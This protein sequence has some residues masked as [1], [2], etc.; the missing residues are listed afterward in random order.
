[1]SYN[2]TMKTYRYIIRGMVQGVAF[3]YYTVKYAQ[4]LSIRGWVKNLFNGDV[5]VLAQGEPENLRGFEVFLQTGPPSAIVDRV[6]KEEV[7]T[8][9]IFPGFQINY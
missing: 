9:E 5:E 2:S 3:R 4:N 7:D 1:M 6:D 8:E